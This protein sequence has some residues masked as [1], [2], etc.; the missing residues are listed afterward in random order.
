MS[1]WP[2]GEPP[3]SETRDL[4][5]LLLELAIAQH[6]AK[7]RPCV[8][9]GLLAYQSG[10]QAFLGS[11]FS[12]RLNTFA[13]A[14]AQHVQ[15]GID[16]VA[17]DAVH[18]AADVADLGKF[19]RFDLEERRLRQLGQPAGDFCLAAAGGADHQYVLGHDFFANA[20]RQLLPAPAVAQRNGDRALGVALPHDE[21][22]KFRDDLSRGVCRDVHFTVTR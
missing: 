1:N 13:A 20:L 11:G 7:F 22:V 21:A 8:S 4:D 18:I 3:E 6:A 2:I 14:F 19:R 12:F 15:A 10:D 5:L 17:D 9:G 16:Q